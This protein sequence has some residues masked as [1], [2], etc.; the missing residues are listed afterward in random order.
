M[1]VGGDGE[2]LSWMMRCWE[3]LQQIIIGDIGRGKGG[4]GRALNS[5]FLRRNSMLSTR[6]I[7]S[8]FSLFTFF[9]S[10]KGKSL[11]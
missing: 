4:G 7:S 3:G 1:A 5:C 9:F 8:I 6:E 2:T 11:R 10:K